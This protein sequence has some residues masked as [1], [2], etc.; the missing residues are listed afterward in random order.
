MAEKKEENKASPPKYGVN[1]DYYEMRFKLLQ[2]ML[3]TCAEVSIMYEHVL[4][5]AQK[6]IKKANKLTNSVSKIA[7]KWKGEELGDDKVIKELQGIVTTFA[8]LIGKPVVGMPHTVEE[9]LDL[10]AE[11][12]K[13]HAELIKKGESQAAT[14]FMCR[15]I[16]KNGVKVQWPVIS[17]HMILGNIKEISRV[18]TNNGDKS[19][20]PSKVSIGE[21]C[22][23][24]CKAI[25]EFMVP[26]QDIVRD[27]DG[28]RVLDERPIRFERAGKE[29]TA[30]AVSEQLPAGT[31]FGCILR[32]R[33]KSPLTEDAL[34]KIFDFGKSKG[35]GAWRS[36]GMRGAYRF[37]L[38]K[39]KP[40][41]KE[42]VP[43][44]FEGWD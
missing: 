35:L 9:L 38:V 44:G 33:K 11:V 26:D 6:E 27:K 37:K 20:F 42:P 16:E 24:D 13:E 41:Y 21:V 31:E 17:T 3:G 23:L 28:K 29:Q 22:S 34:R 4:K 40:S 32:V 5:K 39:M 10:A 19:I 2:P 18:I 14:V 15:T 8:G 30:I 36:S 12:E 25:E 43:P 7:D 1:F